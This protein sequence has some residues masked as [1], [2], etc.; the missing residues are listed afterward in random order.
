MANT[1]FGL[2][3]SKSGLYAYNAAMNTAAHNAANVDTKGYSRQQVRQ[4]ASN[5]ISVSS[6]YG[7]QGTGVNVDGVE[8]VR[9]AYYD[10]KYWTNC[11]V[12]GNYESKAYYMDSVQS[13]F[14][15]VTSDGSTKAFN[16]MFA[17]MGTLSS[18]N[19]GDL[20]IRTQVSEFAVSLTETINS[21][22]NG[23]QSLQKECNA[24]IKTT[25]DQIN[26]IAERVSSLTLQINTIEVSGGMANDLR[27]ARNLLIDE[28]STLANTSVTEVPMSENK[29][30]NQFIVR[31]DGKTLVD[32]YSYTTLTAVPEET[33]VNQNNV[34]GLYTLKWTDGQNFDSSSLTLGGKLQ[35]LFEMRDGN[36]KLPFEGKGSGTAGSTTLTVKGTNM[37]DILKLN[38]ADENGKITVGS[39]AYAYDS[40]T[41]KLEADGTYTYTFQLKEGL[42]ENA[43][44]VN[45]NIG[46]SIDYKGIPYYQAK[47]NEFAR[48]FA[49]AFNDI[50]KQ[51]EDLKNAKGIDFFTAKLAGS[52]DELCFGNVQE[53]FTSLPDPVADKTADDYVKGSYYKMTAG[54]LKVTT[55]IVDHPEKIA[56]SEYG[57]DIDDGVQ[58]KVILDQLIGLKS[59]MNVFT[60][61]T[62]NM[63][64]QTMVAEISIDTK[65][66]ITF[67]ESQDNI[68]KLVESQRMSI[69][70][71]D[72]DEEGMSMMKYRDAYNLCSKVIS[73]MNQMYD[74]LINSMGL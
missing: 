12:Y 2:S 9:E 5:A 51:G 60:Q 46:E 56:C 70:G 49:S 26:S 33:S 69:S 35:A 20:T 3:I 62:P 58:N 17:A 31:I 10:K 63:F 71:V 11:S 16:Q 25:A 36:N 72:G 45:V 47:L 64:L 38:I 7:M 32:T 44:D 6:H 42:K 39:K 13:Y 74:K 24:E 68:L 59:N 27:D 67:S 57:K 52:G 8:Q 28:L 37:N 4:S 41:A 48:T 65:T 55:A 61:G 18:G 43:A 22:Y 53:D 19:I 15:E 30:V 21:M 54:N 50:H 40:F 1:F 73:I 14:S 66:A 34:D 29:G 23:L